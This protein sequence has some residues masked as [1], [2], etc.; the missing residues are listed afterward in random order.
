MI[1]LWV[2][3]Y[4]QVVVSQRSAPP[5]VYLDHW[6]L[7]AISQDETLADRFVRGLHAR[8][9]TLALSWANLSE[10]VRVRHEKQARQAE[11]MLNQTFPRLFFLEVNPWIVID[12]EDELLAGALLDDPHEDSEFLRALLDSNAKSTAPFSAHDLF[13]LLRDDRLVRLTEEVAGTF[14]RQITKLRA[15]M[16]VDPGLQAV[17]RSLPKGPLLQR[18]TRLVLRELVRPLAADQGKRLTQQDATDFLHAVVPVA[19][20]DLVLLDKQWAAQIEQIRAR[21]RAADLDVPLAVVLTRGQDGIEEL[22]RKLEGDVS[23]R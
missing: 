22:L 2:G 5:V 16:A 14:V 17:A 18:R 10:F 21:F 9:G 13:A 12:R 4:G 15:E 11:R 8:Q 20:C 23:Q 7:R 19:Y 3:D 6:A 1:S